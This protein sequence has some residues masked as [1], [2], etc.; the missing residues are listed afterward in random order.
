MVRV[1]RWIGAGLI[2]GAIG[3]NPAL[4]IA[5]NVEA[6]KTDL[7]YV[8]LFN[9]YLATKN[10]E[11]QRLQLQQNYTPLHMSVVMNDPKLTLAALNSGAPVDAKASQGLTPLHMSVLAGHREITTLLLAHRAKVNAADD[12]GHTPLHFAASIGDLEVVKLLVARGATL[13][14]YDQYGATPITM[15]RTEKHDE[16]V[17][18]LIK[19]GASPRAQSVIHE[20]HQGFAGVTLSPSDPLLVDATKQAKQSLGRFWTL[21]RQYP[22]AATVKFTLATGQSVWAMVMDHDATSRKVTVQVI[23]PMPGAVSSSMVNQTI[24]ESKIEDWSVEPSDALVFGKYSHRA[25]CDALIRELGYLPHNYQA[26]AK[27]FVGY[28]LKS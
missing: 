20:D 7:E 3:L 8:T 27:R 1:T 22:Q 24:D 16:V 26:M 28:S 5:A 12:D 25:I 6:P 18:Q 13:D 23:T 15:A 19:L 14:V 10:P 17:A 2:I 9:R 11:L 21:Y 4:S